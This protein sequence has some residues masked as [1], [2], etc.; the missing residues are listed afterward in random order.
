MPPVRYSRVSRSKEL[1]GTNDS[2]QYG[3][4][5]EPRGGR[6]PTTT[7]VR[8]RYGDPTPGGPPQA[9][10]MAMLSIDAR[11]NHFLT[12][13]RD[14]FQRRAVWRRRALTDHLRA[15]SEPSIHKPL[16]SSE[17]SAML[18]LLA[19]E[20]V[21]GPWRRTWVRFGYNTNSDSKSRFL[22]VIDV[23][24]PPQGT[25]KH[26]PAATITLQLCDLVASRIAQ[27]KVL[28]APRCR[29]CDSIYGWFAPTFLE[30][31]ICP[32]VRG[33]FNGE[34]MDH[35]PNKQAGLSWRE[36]LDVAAV[37]DLTV[38]VLET[39]PGQENKRAM[40]RSGGASPPT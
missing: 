8:V 31:T 5:K 34:K 30:D 27:D 39:P 10:L 11:S 36:F 26:P 35:H 24:S 32:L 6:R 38:R 21:S 33:D 16:T 7:P 19:Y 25:N 12:L 15:Y 18:P 1:K 9:A 29:S 23:R 28:G 14:L 4:W 40:S 2:Y 37:A 13:L 22:Q 20:L 17:L 3:T